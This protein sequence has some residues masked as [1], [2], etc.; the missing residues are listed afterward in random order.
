MP[1]MNEARLRAVGDQGIDAFICDSTNVLRDGHSPSESDVAATLDRI[2]ADAP[3]RVAVTTFA[4]HVGRI[5]SA[6][7]SARRASRDV[8]VVGRAMRNVIEAARATGYLRD[9]RDFLDEEAFG[10]IPPERVMLLCTGSQGEPRA[11]IARIAE[12][13]HPNVALEEGDIVIFSSKTIPGNE[14]AVSTVLNN[15]ARLGVDA[16]T[17]DD[18]LVHSSGH[19]RRG[20]LRE[21]YEWLRPRAVVPVHGEARHL[22]AHAVFAQSCGIAEAVIADNG[23]IIRLAPGPATIIDEAPAGR[24]HVDGRLIVPADDGPARHRR[25]LSFSGVVVV[26]LVLDRKDN[27]AT[28]PQ[29]AID[30]LPAFD[31]NGREMTEFLAEVVE[32]VFDSLPRPRRKDAANVA[33]TLRVAVR[34]A[35]NEAWGKK[36][37]CRV[38]L[39]RL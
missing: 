38:I 23:S 15:L 6:V 26:T 35:A 11:A 1:D 14:K 24:L 3:R 5:T 30:G 7:R 28:D 22:R 29:V 2:I 21:L 36:P 12:D 9:S 25:R 19:P 27:L 34:R 18:A 33:E 10:Y 20:E 31:G 39:H 8:V 17:S 4:S 37:V 16:I 13:T 32:E